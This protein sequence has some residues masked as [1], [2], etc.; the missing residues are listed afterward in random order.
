MYHTLVATEKLWV[1]CG[2]FSMIVGVVK[3][4]RGRDTSGPY[5]IP[6]V[7]YQ[8]RLGRWNESTGLMYHTL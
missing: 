1:A 6:H 2:T 8:C 5:T 3:R 4:G 7:R